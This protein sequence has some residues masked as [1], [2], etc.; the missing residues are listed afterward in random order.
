MVWLIA[1]TIRVGESSFVSSGNATV[2]FPDVEFDSTNMVYLVV[3]GQFTVTG[4][5][6]DRNGARLGNSFTTIPSR[7]AITARV[8]YAAGP[9]LF[10]SRS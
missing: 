1:L 9:N 3:N 2:R 8:S 6:L 10:S 5:F 4:Q 7:S